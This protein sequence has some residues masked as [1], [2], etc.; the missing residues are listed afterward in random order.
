MARDPQEGS[1]SRQSRLKKGIRLGRPVSDRE[2]WPSCLAGRGWRTKGSGWA[3][4]VGDR[5]KRRLPRQR[6]VYHTL[7][8]SGSAG[9][10]DCE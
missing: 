7:F 6:G 1:D 10:G 2:E 3:G 5:R 8:G 9:L 4:R